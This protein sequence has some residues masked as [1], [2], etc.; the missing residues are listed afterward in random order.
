MVVVAEAVVTVP[1]EPDHGAHNTKTP[2]DSSRM[3]V[4]TLVF[5]SWNVCHRA[6]LSSRFLTYFSCLAF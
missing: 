3:R 2:V 5:R 6:D 4:R 1:V